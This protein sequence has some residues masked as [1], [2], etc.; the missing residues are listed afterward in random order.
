MGEIILS[1]SMRDYFDDLES[2]LHNEIKIANSARSRG[3]DPKPRMEIP[4][5]KDL[6]DRV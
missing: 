1:D 4:L 5:A 6:A 2:R 3:R